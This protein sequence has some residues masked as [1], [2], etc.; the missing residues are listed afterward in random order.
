MAYGL[1]TYDSA[2]NSII[3]ITDRLSRLFGVY[4]INLGSRQGTTVSVPGMATD[5]TWGLVKT[6]SQW[7]STTIQAN[8]I[9]CFNTYYY[10]SM[11]ATLI[12]FRF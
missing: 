8:G 10:N 6:G 7:I 4:S 3:T 1:Q 9:Y 11:P 2:G 5:G 12:V